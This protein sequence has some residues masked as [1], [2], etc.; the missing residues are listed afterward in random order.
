MFMKPIPFSLR[1]IKRK[2]F[3]L[4]FIVNDKMLSNNEI[5]LDEAF[6]KNT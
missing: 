6:L 3:E 4:E 5:Y 1:R 2:S